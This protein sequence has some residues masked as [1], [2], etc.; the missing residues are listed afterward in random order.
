MIG[1]LLILFSIIPYHTPL[2]TES[3]QIEPDYWPTNGWRIS[4]P[5]EQGMSS[6]K[7]QELQDYLDYIGWGFAVRSVLIIRNGYLVHEYYIS[8]EYNE[9]GRN[10]FSCT[11]SVT[12]CLVGI[13]LTDGLIGSIDDPVLDYFP[14]YT[15]ANRDSRKEAMSIRDLLTMTSG[16]QWDEDDY[17]DHGNDFFSMTSSL[18]WVQYVL[19]RPM[20]TDPGWLWYYNSGCS[21]LLSAIVNVTTGNTMTFAQTRLFEPLGMDL[22]GWTR[23]PQLVPFG[24]SDLRICPRDMA[25]FGYLFLNNGT[26]EGQQIVPAAWVHDSIQ[27]ESVIYGTLGYGFQWWVDSETHHFSARGYLGQRIHIIPEEHIVIVFTGATNIA[28]YNSLIYDYIVPAIDYT[29]PSPTLPINEILLGIGVTV[30]VSVIILL[31]VL[32]KRK[33]R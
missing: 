13:A 18:D 25:K 5:E 1:L 32:Y 20:E 16:I 14:D 28:D 9:T 4:T 31:A 22:Q 29:P 7:L 33:T 8:P 12:S 11:K 19:D 2:R 27:P 3:K 23:D 10:I 26:W 17:Q 30:T 6:E 15:I 24:G 21:H